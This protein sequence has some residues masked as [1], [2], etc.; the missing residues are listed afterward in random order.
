MIAAAVATVVGGVAVLMAITYYGPAGE[1]HYAYSA[2]D[3]KQPRTPN[4][5]LLSAGG[6]DPPPCYVDPDD[7]E[8]AAADLP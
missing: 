3:P 7:P 8:C 4:T 2:A 5:P 6:H 1:Q